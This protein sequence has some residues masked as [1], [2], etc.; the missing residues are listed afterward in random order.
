MN[1]TAALVTLACLPT[2]GL[3]AL[4]FAHADEPRAEVVNPRFLRVHEQGPARVGATAGEV[5]AAFGEPW[6]RVRRPESEGF[7]CWY[8]DAARDERGGEVLLEVVFDRATDRVVG[9]TR[10]PR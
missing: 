2:W 9:V 6:A 8:Y 3:A 1:R 5:R 4:Y 10:A 7:V